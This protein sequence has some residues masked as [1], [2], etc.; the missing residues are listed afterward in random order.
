MKL[1]EHV[2]HRLGKNAV[3]TNARCTHYENK[4]TH[5]T[6]HFQ[7]ANG[8]TFSEDGSLLIG[9][10]GIHSAVR[11][12][13]HPNQ[14]DVNWNGAIMWRGVSHTKPPRTKNSFVMVGGIK[15]R[16]VCYPVQPLDHNGE[17]MLNWIA[18]LRPETHAVDKSDW[19]KKAS[20]E[21]FM[22]AFTDWDFDW[23]N[24]PEIVNYAE[25]IWEY[26]MVDRD[27]LTSW[28]DGRVALMG[29]AAHAMFPHGSGGATQGIVD[30]RIMGAC[31][32]SFGV[33]EHALGKY[34]KKLLGPVN[35]L[36]ERNRQEGPLGVYFDI[37]NRVAQG[38][39]VN[40]AI[41]PNEVKSFMLRY[42]EA[43]GTARDTLNN[44]PP[45]VQV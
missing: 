42:K 6:A 40:E 3:V 5:V 11:Q 37:E 34:E 7:R 28:L 15:Q 43:A 4:G 26:P 32:N 24:I 41:N 13:M 33:T 16:F 22:H 36:V 38:M 25:D 8:D 1:L 10:D 23:L 14:A 31:L 20:Q 2:Q 45:I 19:N 12:Q 29:D 21:A 44:A 35:Q 18:E 27:P 17:T 30:T 39:S 9:A